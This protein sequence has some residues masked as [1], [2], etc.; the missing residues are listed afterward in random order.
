VDSFNVL[1]EQLKDLD[2]QVRS[3]ALRELALAWKAGRIHCKPQSDLVNM[4]CHT[5]FSYNGYG[6]SPSSLAWLAREMGWRA[7]ATVDFDVLDGVEETL[8]ACDLVNVRGAAGLETRAYLPEFA[9]YEINSPG[10][11]GILYHI[12]VGF[13]TRQPVP[14]ASVVLEAMRRRAAERN[15]DMVKRINAYLDPLVIDYDRDV[16]PLT[17]AGNATERHILTAYDAAARRLF[18]RREALIAFWA[19]KLG[20][21]AEHVAASLGETPTP[22]ELVRSKLMK[23]GSVGYVQPGPTTFPPFDEVTKAIIACGAI[24]IYAW[25]DGS[26][27]GEQRIEELLT[28]L[29]NKGVAGINIVP[30]RNWNFPDPQVRAAKVRELYRVVDLARSLDLPIL[31]GTEMNKAGQRL[32]DDFDAEPLRPL[33]GDFVRGADFLYGHTVMQ[34]ALGLGYQSEWARSHLPGRRERNAFYATVGRL[35][36]PGAESLQRLAKLDVSKGPDAVVAHLESLF[37]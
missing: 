36:E 28:L 32:V 13:V 8:A 37:R 25:L 3:C 7:L 4:H 15:R 21:D 17:P 1:R 22:N 16:L 18:P 26:S 31:V 29:I 10:E 35:V 23:R 27:Q 20:V 12:G 9:T 6:H 30:D 14:A 34:R 33:R 2:F 24:P 11:P 19:D 5:C